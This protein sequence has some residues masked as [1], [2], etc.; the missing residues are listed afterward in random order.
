MENLSQR[1]ISAAKEYADLVL[2]EPLSR[3]GGLLSDS[4]GDWK[5]RNSVRL[6]P[7]AKK[8]LDESGISP[9]QIAPSVFVPIVE[10][11]SLIDD[12][13]LSDMF[14]SLLANHIADEDGG[15]IHPSYVKV[16]AQL[17][18]MD[19]LVLKAFANFTASEEARD[20]GLKGGGLRVEFIAKESSTELTP[21]YLS[22][23]NLWRLGIVSH[24]G[25]GWPENH[26]I[27]NV[28]S[29]FIGASEVSYC[30]IGNSI[31]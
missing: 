19:A 13:N 24:E 6:I 14:S 31:L 1:A 22:C 8:L 5:F 11:A 2:K 16:L 26:P 23:L 27:A 29:R 10:E 15:I 18:S 17:S 7:K 9:K 3:L 25:F 20:V 30:G 28:F 12:E 4:V 21:C